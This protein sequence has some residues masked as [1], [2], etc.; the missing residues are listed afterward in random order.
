MFLLRSINTSQI[1]SES[2]IPAILRSQTCHG[3]RCY[4]YVDWKPRNNDLL[5]SLCTT[6]RFW[7]WS[8]VPQRLPI[9]H[10]EV[11]QVGS[12]GASFVNNNWDNVFNFCFIWQILHEFWCNHNIDLTFK[13]K[14]KL[15]RK[16]ASQFLSRKEVALG[17]K[18]CTKWETRWVLRPVPSMARLMH[19]NRSSWWVLLLVKSIRIWCL[20]L[21]LL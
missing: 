12:L 19:I 3:R 20:L 13:R 6:T 4:Y 9:K 7:P 5:A 17:A 2:Q 14:K 15:T 21:L 8:S 10:S 1:S 18:K 11:S 16:L